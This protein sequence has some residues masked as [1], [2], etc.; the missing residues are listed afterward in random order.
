MLD[1]LL[2]EYADKFGK[3]F[4]IFKFMGVSDDEI[5]DLLK[6]CIA[7]GKAYPDEESEDGITY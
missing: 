3:N 7:D 1:D 2:I 5:I 6:S 4:P